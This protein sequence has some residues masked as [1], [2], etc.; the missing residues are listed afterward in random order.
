MGALGVWGMRHIQHKSQPPASL[1]SGHG[2]VVTTWGEEQGGHKCFLIF[3]A[4]YDQSELSCRAVEAVHQVTFELIAISESGSGILTN[5]D[6]RF[7]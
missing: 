1:A 5:S 4:L 3:L 2:K 6:P 7:L